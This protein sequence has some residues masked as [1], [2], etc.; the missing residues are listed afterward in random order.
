MRYT[1]GGAG[2]HYCLFLP[3]IIGKTRPY[4]RYM[5]MCSIIKGNWYKDGVYQTFLIVANCVDKPAPPA[6]IEKLK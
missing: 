4:N 3:K 5:L 6:M 2:L 1:R